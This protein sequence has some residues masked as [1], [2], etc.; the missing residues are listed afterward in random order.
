MGCI[1][2]Q[3]ARRGLP[4]I[5]LLLRYEDVVA[6]FVKSTSIDVFSPEYRQILVAIL[7]AHED[8]VLLTRRS[9]LDYLEAK[10]VKRATLLAEETLYNKLY[11]ER[12]QRDDAPMLLKS[13]IKKQTKEGVIDALRKYK[14]DD[15]LDTLTDAP[16]PHPQAIPT[17]PRGIKFP[18]SLASADHVTTPPHR[19]ISY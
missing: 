2:R 6:Y 19:G 10:K 15:N 9:Y 18:I 7:H 5:N 16:T 12:A 8:G 1:R 14:D 3:R 17:R 13:I 11:L 4:R